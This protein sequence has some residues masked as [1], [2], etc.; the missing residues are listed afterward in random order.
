VIHAVLNWHGSKIANTMS[1]YNHKHMHI[2][3]VE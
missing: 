3:D 2:L 1:S